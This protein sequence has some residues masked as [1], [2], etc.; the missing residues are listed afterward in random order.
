LGLSRHC[1]YSDGVG[2]FSYGSG[3]SS[4]FYSGL[5]SPRS[6]SVLASMKIGEQLSIISNQ[7]HYKIE[8]ETVLVKQS[9][10]S[11]TITFN[12]L[13]HKNSINAV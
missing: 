13:A 2:L 8:Y 5:L 9:A 1:V 12:R 3:C 11:L 10:G 4:E 7:V 6:Q